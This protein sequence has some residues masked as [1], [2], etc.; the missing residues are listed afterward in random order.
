MYAVSSTVSDFESVLKPIHSY[1]KDIQ[2]KYQ[3]VSI[4]KSLR[5]S[6]IDLNKS[7]GYIR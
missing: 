6:K 5:E 1:Q 2:A 4:P 7:L 3:L